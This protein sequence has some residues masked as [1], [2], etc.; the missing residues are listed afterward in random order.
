MKQF[1]RF[2]TFL[3]LA[4]LAMV[5][6]SA[7]AEDVT[8]VLNLT[9]TGVTG[10]SYTTF[11]DKT[12]TSD[13]VYAGQCAG[14]NSS[15]Q[16]RSSSNNSGVVTTT[17]GGKVKS[18]TVEWQSST[19]NG[20]VLN[21]Y[22]KNTAYEAATD[23]YNTSNQGTLL[24][25]IVKGTSTT[26]TIDGDY[27]Y[28]GF[29]SNSGAM[30]LTSV[31]IVWEV[32][33][34]SS[35]LTDND[36]ALTGDPV[37]LSFDLYNNATAQVINYTTSS[38]GEV[39][40]ADN[41]Y[42]TFVVDQTN[43]TIT[44]T[45]TAETPST[46]TIT[47]IQAADE[48][49]A[50]GSVKFTFDVTD[51]TPS[52]GNW[53]ET[54]LADLTSTDIF[55][56]V[57]KNSQGNTYAMS[58]DKGT[59]SA[60][61]AVS[62]TVTD[63][64]ITSKVTDAIKWNISGDATNGYTFY[65]AGSTETW[66]YC[67]N[68]NNGVRVGTN[69][70][71]TF[72]VSTEG[73]LKHSGTTRY[74]GVY[75]QQDWRCYTSINSNI[76]NQTFTFYRYD[77]GTTP[78][79]ANAELAFSS[80]T[81]EATVGESF[82][83]PTL[84]TASGFNGT[85]EYT[86]SDETV[87]QV[88]DAETGEL[89]I[90]SGGTTVITATFAGNE[91]FKSGSASYTL[92]VTDNRTA[93]TIS[94]ESFVLDIADVATLTKLTPVVT[95]ANSNTVSYTYGSWPTEVSFEV[96]SDENGIIGSLDN[97]AGDI[98]LNAVAGTATL[99]A[100]YNLYGVNSTYQPS[101]CTFTIQVY[102]PLDGIAEFCSL[103]NNET[104]V[105]K[106]TDAQ[107][108][109]ASGNDMFVKD[110]T[111]A[112]DF[113]N[114]GLSYAAGDVLNGTIA[115]TYKLYNGM[116]E[117]TTVTSNTLVATSGSTVTPEE[118]TTS[119]AANN[120]CNLVKLTG[121]TITASGNNFYA[122]DVQI[123]DKFQLGYTIEAGKVYDI[124]GIMVPYGSSYELC[125]TEAP[126]ENTTAIALPTFDVAEGT[127]AQGTQVTITSEQG[128]ILT[129]TTDG[130]DP[131][132]STTATT[133]A[134][135][136]ATVTID[137]TTTIRVVATDGTSFSA[138]ASATYTVLDPSLV[139]ATYDFTD[140][141]WVAGEGYTTAEAV[142]SWAVDN[143]VIGGDKGEGSTYPSYYSTNG[144][145]LRIYNNCRFVVAST[146]GTPIT[147]I[148][149]ECS[150]ASYAHVTL[151]AGQPGSLVLS[152]STYTWTPNSG[153]NVV[154]V[155]FSGDATS[156]ISTIT[157]TT[158]SD[159]TVT[160]DV[161]ISAAG[162]GTLYTEQPFEVPAGM[163]AGVI[164]AASAADADGISTLTID[165]AYAEGTIVPPATPLLIKG[166]ANTYTYTCK[167]T[168]AAAP[169]A[170][171]LY[172]SAEATT[173]TGGTN[174]V[175]YMLSYGKEEKAD[176]LGFFYGAPNGGAFESAAGKCWL[177]IA[178]SSGIR[179]FVFGDDDITTGIS[180]VRTAIANGQPVYDL[181]GRRVENASRGVYIIGGKKVM[182]K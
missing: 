167:G 166:D 41:N 108:L 135:N 106:L 129:Y 97:N 120:V 146:D 11:T 172:G 126:V 133:T 178:A 70:S 89:S 13:A 16:L 71:K 43:K 9:F 72:T 31:T 160:E 117:L 171:L 24:G 174:D 104:G 79:K 134:A 39:T 38:T 83:A 8:D 121:V 125:P 81:A 147:S 112:M 42:A 150:S 67:T 161:T 157:V 63:D 74:V 124:V 156:R 96:V 18:I 33:G 88:L 32:V 144:G 59:D 55:V 68:T 138:E 29:R 142:E 27:E 5:G 98:T 128:T 51:S 19:A 26:L 46:Q 48:T 87:A 66:L 113:Y 170:N 92:T 132:T 60:P 14:G 154:L 34:G 119:D 21:V 30:Y 131:L 28:I 127:V 152:G 40:V 84:S 107:V 139:Q 140:A 180:A 163:T 1:L 61:S 93:T 77:D 111:G 148:V 141:T 65:P 75:S 35:T 179:G 25:T 53:V 100:Y 20:R 158:K 49:Y 118:I 52:V 64:E 169:E 44:V 37:A 56:I 78:S 103:S 62:V 101:E 177:A 155:T 115:G 116:P 54:A 85:V 95:D 80:A 17:S 182:V 82:T 149:M 6:N 69:V 151:P 122:D 90:I 76:A 45:P 91:D 22:G 50:A 12:A 3:I 175:F 164:S 162:F 143:V 153:E 110:A 165:W 99:K 86:S 2:K 102:S 94:Q 105:L 136:T 114:T 159:V 58:N 73:Y 10:T 173:T 137:A 15:I 7:W 168:T 109:Y 57:G 4:L 47:V 123:Y 176:V 145:N 181:Q 130:E 23:L 36:L